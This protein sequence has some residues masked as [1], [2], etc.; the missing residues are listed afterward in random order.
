MRQ[1]NDGE[2]IPL[3]LSTSV[4]FLRESG[5]N[6]SQRLPDY[7]VHCFSMFLAFIM[8]FCGKMLIVENTNCLLNH[9]LT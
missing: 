9:K 1:I 6:H 5:R 8:H 3:V 4:T 7:L 2:C